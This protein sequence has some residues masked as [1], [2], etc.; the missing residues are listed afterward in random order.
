MLILASGSP[1]RAKL[2]KDAGLDFK[3]ISSDVEE[4]Y[5]EN[6]EPEEIVKYLAQLKAKDI[7]N[8]HPQDIVVGADTI[9]V[10]QD[11]ILGKPVDEEDAFNMLSMLSNQCHDVYTGVSIL[12][13]DQEDTFYSKTRVCMK[14]LSDVDIKT[15]IETKEPM[16]KAGAYGIQGEG[17][18]L[19]D[20]YEGD[21]FTVMGLPLKDVLFKLNKLNK[22]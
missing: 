1:R 11:H 10:Y 4:I 20:H 8:N 13:E 19:I 15:Y 14:K 7:F 21:F 22:S 17:G 6:L 9:V 18:Q 16:D 2:L 5:D 3:V 12:H